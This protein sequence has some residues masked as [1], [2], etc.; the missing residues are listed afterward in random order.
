VTERI[1]VGH[2]LTRFEAA[3]RAKVGPASLVLRPDLLRIGGWHLEEVYFAFQFDD[4]GVRGDLAWVVQ[5]LKRRFPDDAIADWLARP[6][7]EL[8]TLSPL[9]WLATRRDPARLETAALRSGPRW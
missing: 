4:H 3:R 9:E 7:T 5:G 8:S 1:F 6:N 2:F